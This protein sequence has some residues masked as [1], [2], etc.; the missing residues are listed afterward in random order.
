MPI[1]RTAWKEA[2]WIFLLSRFVI[3]LV[4]YISFSILPP[5]GQTSGHICTLN[6]NS[7]IFSWFHWDAIAYVN[8]ALLAIGSR[9]KPSSF[10]RGPRLLN[11]LAVYFG[12]PTPSNLL[13][14]CPPRTTC[15]CSFPPYF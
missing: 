4:T 9:R 10:P 13:P 8:I 2:A 11:G 3:I 1:Q 7:C 15:S 6:I 12:P 14:T 5:F